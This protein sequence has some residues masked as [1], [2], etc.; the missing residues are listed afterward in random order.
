MAIE[1]II[2]EEEDIKLFKKLVE[3][4]DSGYVRVENSENGPAIVHE[5]GGKEYHFIQSNHSDCMT[6]LSE[7]RENDENGFY[8]FRDIRG[9]TISDA[10][11]GKIA[12]NDLILNVSEKFFGKYPCLVYA[13]ERQLTGKDDAVEIRRTQ[14]SNLVENFFD[15]DDVKYEIVHKADESRAY[16]GASLKLNVKISGEPK[17]IVGKIFFV[18]SGQR[19][20]PLDES[21]GR[22]LSDMVWTGMKKKLNQAK[23]DALREDSNDI[24]TLYSQLEN[25]F[26]QGVDLSQY[27]ILSD[28]NQ[29][30]ITELLR[31]K[32]RGNDKITVT[33]EQIYINSILKVFVKVPVFDIVLHADRG[34]K[35]LSANY[36]GDMLTLICHACSRHEVIVNDGYVSYTDE[37]GI[38]HSYFLSFDAENEP[39]L[40]RDGLP[41][42]EDSDAEDYKAV[43]ENVFRRHIRKIECHNLGIHGDCYNYVCLDD[44][45][46]IEGKPVRCK[47]CP[48][49]EKTIVLNG[50]NYSPSELFFDTDSG[51]IRE[52]SQENVKCKTEKCQNSATGGKYCKLCESLRST[53]PSDIEKQRADYKKYARILPLFRRI[54]SGDKRCVEDYKQF[55]FRLGNK[56]FVI[57]KET[58]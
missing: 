18:V 28:E 43:G 30:V 36:Y 33:C 21:V 50:C 15:L 13:D 45:V 26:K 24:T 23:G 54:G 3:L 10:T 12:W 9:E 35:I 11:K 14:L 39:Y 57:E 47:D 25:F 17:P 1:Y 34:D 29:A 48:Y 6:E 7:N 51:T 20:V 49:L 55:V 32:E 8:W 16:Y 5:L 19:I 4:R 46:T 56:T 27:L 40:S 38:S 31:N 52:K 2:H 41:L 22:Q 37:D 42:S 44:T 53:A 58:L